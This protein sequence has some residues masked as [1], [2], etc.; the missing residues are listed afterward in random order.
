MSVGKVENMD[1]VANAGSVRR[2]IVGTEDLQAGSRPQRR[3]K[4][5]RDQV[6]LWGVVLTTLLAGAR[7]VEVTE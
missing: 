1:V 2:R 3:R 7:G 6:G 5:E 4:G